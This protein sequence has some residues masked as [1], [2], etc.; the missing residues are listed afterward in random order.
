MDF[1]TIGL[2]AKEG[3]SM[4][5][6]FLFALALLF[7]FVGFCDDYARDGFD[8]MVASRLPVNQANGVWM[9]TTNTQNW[10]FV[11][12][13]SGEADKPTNRVPLF[14]S[15]E[16]INYLSVYDA[17]QAYSSFYVLPKKKTSTQDLTKHWF[18]QSGEIVFSCQC[19]MSPADGI[20]QA[21]TLSS[22][23]VVSFYA[24][25]TPG[26][27][28]PSN[29][30]FVVTAYG[31]QQG[32]LA[33]Q[34]FLTDNTLDP[35]AWHKVS[36]VAVPAFR[37][38]SGISYG[39]VF[40]LD[41]IL[42]TSAA[43]KESIKATKALT[44]IG[45]YF[46]DKNALWIL[47]AEA[48][49]RATMAGTGAIDDVIFTTNLVSVL[50]SERSV[51]VGWG[52]EFKN[53][54]VKAGDTVLYSTENASSVEGRY[55]CLSN[56]TA[57]TQ[58]LSLSYSLTNSADASFLLPYV[59]SPIGFSEIFLDGLDHVSVP[60]PGSFWM[61]TIDIGT[62]TC[63]FTINGSKVKDWEFIISNPTGDNDTP[64]ILVKSTMGFHAESIQDM[65]FSRENL[66]VD[67]AGFDLDLVCLYRFSSLMITNSV[68]EKES[69]LTVDDPGITLYVE[70]ID[71][72]PKFIFDGV[73]VNSAI[74]IE[75]GSDDQTLEGLK[76][77]L[78]LQSGMFSDV[79]EDGSVDAWMLRDSDGNS[80]FA[81]TNFVSAT[82]SVTY[83]NGYFCVSKP[84]LP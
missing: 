43:T 47:N 10:A 59:Q 31:M 36:C 23:H 18:G 77:A 54:Q 71:T 74:C 58:S 15:E 21:D 22:K 38:E 52:R 73:T 67:L 49:D 81:M 61:R 76:S 57:G 80:L 45:E 19:K 46:N 20:L 69:V 34:D 33:R 2:C 70:N 42:V 29:A 63:P 13:Y 39:A 62:Y 7:P 14:L 8:A 50:P 55:A 17:P 11:K 37:G 26:T 35:S 1:L 84:R 72:F 25:R 66:I 27:Q 82:S 75:S 65:L 24:V 12:A 5:H 64:T 56:I 83:S 30:T 48:W 3:V 32:S 51:V 79:Y 28:A 60:I 6:I 40:Y 16:N 9:S 78:S 41:D 53:I 68:P 4:R 44:S